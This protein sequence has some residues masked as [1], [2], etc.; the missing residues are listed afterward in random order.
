MVLLHGMTAIFTYWHILLIILLINWL[1]IREWHS[2][3]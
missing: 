1:H 2:P 3:C